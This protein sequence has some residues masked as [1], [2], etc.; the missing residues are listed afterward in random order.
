MINETKRIQSVE[1]TFLILEALAACENAIQ[2][3]QLSSELMINKTTLHGLLN[4]MAAMGYVSNSSAGYSLGMRLNE[5]SRSLVCKYDELRERYL[6]LI[7]EM[8]STTGN[9]AYLAV[10]CGSREYLYIEAVEGEHPLTIR[11]PRGKR[12]GLTTSAI[13]KLFLALDEEQDLRRSLRKASM[14]DAPLEQKLD[15]IIHQG[16]SIDHG[17]AQE[18]LSC[19]SIPLYQSGKL[20]AAAGMSGSSQELTTEKLSHY[21]HIFKKLSINPI[22]S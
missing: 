2:L 16:Y 15:Q 17:G 1:R 19:M 18:G 3:Q 11:S 4:T 7:K 5:L 8:A 13:G 14:L 9:T 10:P 20:V 21:A 6:P 22:D 12:E